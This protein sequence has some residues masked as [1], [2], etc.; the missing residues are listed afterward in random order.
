[1]EPTGTAET[2]T[3]GAEA[4]ALLSELIRFNTV[5]PPGNE[6]AAQEHVAAILSD[7]GF[8]VELLEREPDRTNVVARLPG[9][10]EGPILAYISH[11]DTVPADPSEWSF[12]P[13]SGDVVDGFVQGRGGQDMKDQVA[14]EVAA[15]AYLARSGWRPARGEL[16]VIVAADEELGAHMGAKWLTQEHPE[17]VRADFVVNEGGGALFEIDG[18]RFYPV[19]LGEKGVFRFKLRAR[20]RAG[21]GS[22]PSLGDNALL[23]LAPAIS[24]LV[25]QPPLQATAAGLEFLQATIGRTVDTDNPGDLVAALAELSRVAPEAA[26][27]MAEPMLRVTLVPTQISGSSADNV[28]PAVA[29]VVVDCRVP[30]G[31]GE[32]HVREEIARVLGSQD[33]SLEIEFDDRTVGNESP[34]GTELADAIREW[35]T[36]VDPEATLVPTVMPGFSDSHW[37]RKAFGSCVVYGFHPQRELDMLAAAPLV[38][39]ADEGA[40]VADVELAADF[41]AWLARR[42]LG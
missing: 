28:I 38:H 4:V 30:P 41:Y 40:A 22:V 32:E 26:A 42:I 6:R 29:E 20:G 16:K 14:T 35:L 23:R 31:L 15:A 1:M 12:S 2:G 25:E 10:A 5:N 39:G 33:P 19:S 17:K 13:W 18:R 3:L 21:H 37:F 8:E 7:A 36:E 11:M 34:Y 9:E 27:F 24:R